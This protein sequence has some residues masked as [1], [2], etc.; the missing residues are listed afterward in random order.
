V[1]EKCSAAVLA[2][3]RAMI[4]IRKRRLAECELGITTEEIMSTAMDCIRE[5]ESYL[6][7]LLEEGAA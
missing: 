6:P 2:S 5:I 1:K 4:D 7:P 3:A